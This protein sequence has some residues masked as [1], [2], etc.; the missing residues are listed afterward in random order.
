MLI[1]AA[2][3]AP[4]AIHKTATNAIKGWILPGARSIPEIAVK[5]TRHNAWFH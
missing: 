1:A 5:T 3:P 2:E 4:M